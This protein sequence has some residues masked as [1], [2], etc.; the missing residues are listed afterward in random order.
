MRRVGYQ[1]QRVEEKSLSYNIYYSYS[2]SELPKLYFPE[3]SCIFESSF[4]RLFHPLLQSFFTGQVNLNAAPYVCVTW[5]RLALKGQ[6]TQKKNVFS[7]VLASPGDAL[8]RPCGRSASTPD[9]LWAD[10]VSCVVL[11]TWGKKML[12][13]KKFLN[14]IFIIDYFAFFFFF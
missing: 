11:T 12:V 2:G 4:N 9:T 14:I 3:V 1:S 6:F 8:R 5:L 13:K 7:P 10:G